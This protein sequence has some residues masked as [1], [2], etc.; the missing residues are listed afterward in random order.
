[1]GLLS[2]NDLMHRY[3]WQDYG[4]TSPE[5]SGQPDQTPFDPEDGHQVLYIINTFAEYYDL[6]WRTSGL[7]AENI[8]KDTLPGVVCNQIEVMAWLRGKWSKLK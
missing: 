5:V 6:P 3:E 2:K 4:E 1:M 8:L 7:M